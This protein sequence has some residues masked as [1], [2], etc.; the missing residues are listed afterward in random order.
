MIADGVT[1]AEE[2]IFIN[3]KFDSTLCTVWYLKPDYLQLYYEIFC[4]CT[5]DK[6]FD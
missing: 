1:Y 3:F 4:T 2:R 5:N 6:I